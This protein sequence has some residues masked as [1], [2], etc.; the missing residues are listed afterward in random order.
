MSANDGAGGDA[1]W[2]WTL[3]L[4]SNATAGAL[5]AVTGILV[6]VSEAERAAAT[7]AGYT[8]LLGDLNSG[9]GGAVVTLH[10]IRSSGSVAAGSLNSVEAALSSNS[11]YGLVLARELP[12]N[13]TLVAGNINQGVLGAAPLFLYYLSAPSTQTSVAITWKPCACSV[14][15]HIICFSGVSK[16]ISNA[17]AAPIYTVP[18]CARINVLPRLAPNWTTTSA[19]SSQ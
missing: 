11:L 3:V 18:L 8:Q 15:I 16:S 7:A 6:A 10:I 5:A 19:K 14:G 17:S 2:V 12:E 13:A 4:R 9:T 1:V